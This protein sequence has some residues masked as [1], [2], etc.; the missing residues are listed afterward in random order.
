MN[1]L[2]GLAKEKGLNY[3]VSPNGAICY[4]TSESFYIEIHLAIDGEV[5]DVK[6][7]H[8]GKSS[9]NCE[10]LLQLLSGITKASGFVALQSLEKDLGL[11]S[12]LHKTPDMDRVTEVLCGKVGYLAPSSRGTPM[13]LEYYLSQYQILDEQIAGL[14]MQGRKVFVTIKE[15]DA[16]YRLPLAPL[17]VSSL[18]D[19]DRKAEESQHSMP[20]EHARCS[21]VTSP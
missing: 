1:T 7:A 9:R 10:D 6:L 4:I 15:T 14:K 3:H 18:T 19:E 17:I 8:P 21:A 5:V 16:S 13:S 2:E 20:K 11:L 12:A